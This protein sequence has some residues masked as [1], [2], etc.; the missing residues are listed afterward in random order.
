[1]LGVAVRRASV[2]RPDEQNFPWDL[3]KLKARKAGQWKDHGASVQK[4]RIMLHRVE[5][6][7]FHKDLVSLLVEMRIW[8]DRHHV[9]ETGFEHSLG[10]PGMTV[11]VSFNAEPQAE[12]F[13]QAFGGRLRRGANPGG[14]ALWDVASNTM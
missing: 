13:A 5:I 11:R 2:S 12:A 10:G 1:V 4:E 6:R 9:R 7:R 8:L 14:T 3:T